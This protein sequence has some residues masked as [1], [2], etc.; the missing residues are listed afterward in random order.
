M[1]WTTMTAIYFITWWTVLFAVLPWGVRSQTEQGDVVPGTD[2]GA[3]AFPQLK[4]KIVWTT[5]VTTILFVAFYYAFVTRLIT[6][7]GL[8]SI[9]GMP[10]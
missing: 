8:T 6:I 5:V 1:A 7:D 4:S 3:P 9:I 10:R 2:P